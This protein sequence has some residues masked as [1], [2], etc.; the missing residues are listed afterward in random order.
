MYFNLIP[1]ST[2]DYLPTMWVLRGTLDLKKFGV[3]WINGELI[4]VIK[5][6]LKD[7]FLEVL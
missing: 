1:L 4:N 7:N 3:I 5:F 2:V 6:P